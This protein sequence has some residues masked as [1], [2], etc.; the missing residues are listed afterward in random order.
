[1]FSLYVAL[2]DAKCPLLVIRARDGTI[3]EQHAVD[4]ETKFSHDV[5]KYIMATRLSATVT[6]SFNDSNH[7]A[8]IWSDLVRAQKLLPV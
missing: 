7:C 6:F 3:L 2:Q 5:V 1:V 4:G 8:K